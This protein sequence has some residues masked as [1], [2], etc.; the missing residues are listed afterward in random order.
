MEGV[1]QGALDRDGALKE[2]LKL[3]C[4]ECVC[5]ELPM[6]GAGSQHCESNKTEVMRIRLQTAGLS[7]SVPLPGSVEGN[8]G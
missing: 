6:L 2:R 7:P 8:T 5:C 1:K 3:I 4:R